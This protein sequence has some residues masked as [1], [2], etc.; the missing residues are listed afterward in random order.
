[1]PVDIVPT[2]YGATGRIVGALQNLV[3]R[4]LD[5]L[6]VFAGDDPIIPLGVGLVVG[7]CAIP[8]R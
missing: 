1:M 8:I 7:R 6:V 5:A 2:R 3:V 4:D